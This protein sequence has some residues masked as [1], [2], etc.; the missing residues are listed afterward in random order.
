MQENELIEAQDLP[1]TAPQ[2]PEPRV[3]MVLLAQ[4]GLFVFCAGIG[5]FLYKFICALQVGKY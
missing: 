1:A 2:L 5:V 3:R 4:L